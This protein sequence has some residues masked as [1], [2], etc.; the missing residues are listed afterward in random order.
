MI[1]GFSN[2]ENLAVMVSVDAAG[3]VACIGT[4]AIDRS[5]AKQKSAP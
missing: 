5:R 3:M 4:N 1:W 2:G